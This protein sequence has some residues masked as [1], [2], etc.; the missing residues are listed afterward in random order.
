MAEYT[1][2]F[3]GKFALI[4]EGFPSFYPDPEALFG[5]MLPSAQIN[6]PGSGLNFARFKNSEV[7]KLMSEQREAANPVERLRML[8]R[9][10]DIVATEAPYRPLY[11]IAAIAGLSDKFVYPTF[12]QWSILFTP[13]AMNVKLAS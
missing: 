6:L 10:A 13:W 1:N 2:I 3:A 9:L 7:D 4:V 5:L 12:S 8:G 11:S